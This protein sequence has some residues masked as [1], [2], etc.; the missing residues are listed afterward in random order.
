L[1][2]SDHHSERTGSSRIGVLG[3]LL[4]AL[5]LSLGAA[6]AANAQACS[7]Y[8]GLL[9]GFAGDIPPPQLQIDRNCTIRN[10]PASN[11]LSTN[12]SFF[13]QPGQND[14]RYLVVFDNVVHTGQMSCNSNDVQNHKIWFTNGSSTSI[15]DKCQELLIP[16]EK[17]D[18][19]NPAGQTTAAIGVPFTY[20]LTI[21][22]LFDP[23]T[24][25]VI[26]NAGS[27]N[28]LHSVIVT[29]DLNATN[30]DLSYVS[31]TA[32]WR[33]S[34]AAVPHA[35]SNVGG[36][37]TFDIGPI[38]PAGEQIDIAITVVLEDT[39]TNAPGTPF[40]NTAKWE[41]GR[42]I[43]GVFYEP[44]PGEWGISPPLT[45]AAPELVMTKTG[46]AT[47]GLTLNLGEWGQFGL[48]VE[49]TGLTDAWDITL[50]DQLP[51]PLD[52]GMCATTPEI[53]SAEIAESGGG[54]RT[55]VQGADY[56]FAYAGAPT[57]EFTLSLLSAAGPLAPGDH[58]V[59]GYR[60]RLDPDTQDGAMLTNVA[61]ATQWFNDQSGN[62]DR[63]TFPRSLTD[64]T[65]GDPDH[66]DAHT[67]TAAL[68]GYFFEKSVANLTTG[69]SPT[70]TATPG[71][72]LRYTLR[73]QATDVE[74]TD[75]TIRDDLGALNGA[76]VFVPGSLSLV[77]IPAGATDNSLPGGGTN[78]AGLLEIANLDVPAGGQVQI[79]FDIQ[80]DPSLTDG[81]LVLNQADL[82]SSGLD[83]ADSDDPNINGQADPSVPGDEDPTQVLVEA[84]P[85]EPLSKANTQATATIGET[86]S[87]LVTLPSIPHTA[88]LYDVRILDDLTLSA[89]DL[90][91]VSVSTSG[92]WTLVNT[93]S[94]T[95]LV[96]E[97]TGTGIDIP[98]GEQIEVEITVRL[99]D[100]GT[101]VAGLD[102][103]NTATFTYNLVNED[104]LS[105]RPGGPGTTGPMT[106][107]EPE[108]TLEKTGP[109]LMTPGTAGSF[110]L[111]VHNA[112]GSPAWAP[113]ITDAL[114]DGPTGGTCDAMPTNVA[115]QVFESDGSTPVSGVLAQGTDY[116]LS[117]SGTLGCL[118][119][120]GVLSDQ[121]TI[122][123]DQRL[124]ISYDALLDGDTQNGVALTNVAGAVEWFGLDDGAP[125]R[126]TYSEIVTD[127]TP[128]LLDHQDVHTVAVA[129]PGYRF[130]K[131]VTN[132]TTGANPA[133]TASPG[134][135]LLYRLELT[136]TS[137]EELDELAIVDELDALN[138]PAAFQ[139]DTLQLISTP[140]GAITG[141]TLPDGGSQGTG[142]LDVRGLTLPAMGSLSVEFQIQ[143]APV[144]ANG[145]TVAN[146]SQLLL[147]DALFALS[148]DPNVNGQADPFVPDDE[149]PTRLLIQSAP[150]FQVQKISDDLT[151][152][153]NVLLAGETLRYTIRVKN[154]G[155]DDASDAVLRDDVPVNTTYVPGSTTLNGAP[156][157]DG[158]GG[159]SP[160]AAG[161]PINAPED[162]TPGAMR[163]DASATPD[164]VATL[165]FD[166][167]V[168]TGVADGTLIA[169]QGFVSA[170]AGNVFDT[171]SDDPNTPV[172]NDPTRDVVGSVPLL[173][174]TKS[175]ELLIDNDP[176]G[177]VN[178]LDV[179]HY[180]IE[181]FNTG[182]VPATGV[183]VTDGV[184][185][186]TAYVANSTTLNTL[187][188]A[189]VGGPPLA[190]GLPISSSDLTPPLP[191]P[192]GGTISVGGSALIEFDLQ[193]D[194]DAQD[195]TVISNQ[196]LVTGD[197]TP[198]L[199]T[200]GDGDP[201][202]G[203]EPT[204]VVV[205]GGPQLAITKQVAVV[206]GGP[207][208][209]G[210]TVEY[211]VNVV[212]IGVVAASSVVI[213][214]DV[215]P[216][217]SYVDP[218]AT[219]NGSPAGVSFA[220]TT[221]TA[222]Y[223]ASYGDLPSGGSAQL[224]FRAVIDPNPIGT[225]VT[226]T[227][228]VTWNTTETEQASAS[229][230]VGG[231][232]G[233]GVLSGRLWHDVDF[234]DVY[235]SGDPVL[236]G[237]TVELL[238][239]G[240][241]L[242]STVS[243]ADGSYSITGVPPNDVSGDSLVL[244]FRAPDAGANSASLGMAASPFT[245]GPQE[246]S[247]I[248]V[249]GG[250]IVE[251]LNLPI[252]PNGVVY[253]ALQRTPVVGATLRMLEPGSLTELPSD[254]FEDPAQQGQVTRGDGFYKF[255]LNFGQSAC[256]SPGGSYLI[257]VTPPGA[258]FVAG[259]SQI[260]P[261]ISDDTT[262]PLDV[263]TCPG[264][265]ND[266]LGSPPGFCEA[267]TFARIPVG[268]E[269]TSY[270]VH[271]FLGD[272]NVPGTSQIF[273]N[274]IP[275]D[276]VLD[277]V[278]AI[279]K[280]TPLVNVSRGQLVPYEI[281]VR[282][283]FGADLDGV[284]IVDRFPPGFHYVEGSAQIDGVRVE[285][286][287][288][289]R[290]LV[291]SDLVLPAVSQRRL[292]LL[293][294]VG[295]G[296]SEG[297]FVNRAQ[298]IRNGA[299]L[300]GQA[301]ATVRVVPDPTFD[302]TDVL[303][304]VFDDLDRDGIQDRGERGL[305]GVRLATA[306]G[307]IATTD[308]HG[309]F[310]ITCAITPRD[311]RGS[312]FV[313]KLDD[314][315]LPSGYR[316]STRQV[317]VKRATAGK[318]LRFSYGASIHRVVG[319]DLADAVFEPGSA[320]MRPQWE[321]RLDLLLGELRKAPAILRLS[322]VADVESEDLVVRR[323]D[324]IK[325]RIA[326][327]WQDRDGYELT[328]ETEIFWRRGAPLD[329]PSLPA[330]DGEEP[331]LPPVS[332]GP[333]LPSVSAGPPPVEAGAGASAERQFP[334][335]QPFVQWVQDPELLAHDAS[336]RLEEREV[337]ADAV[338]TV[339]LK[340]VVP[341]VRFESGV[342]QISPS[343]IEELR[344]V[345]ESMRHLENVRL[346]L[347]GHA[348]D[349]PLSSALSNIYGD[350]AGLSR[351]RAGE[352]AEFIQMALG[353][354]P[355]AISF[356]WAGDSQPVAS[357]AT[358]EG[359]ALNRRVEVEVWYDEIGQQIAREEVVVPADIKRIKVC[360]METVCKL[361]Y[362]EGHARRSRI[363]NLIPPLR[364]D[365]DTVGVPADFI[366]QLERTLH[367][368]RDKQNV[369]V[370][371]IGFTDDV[372][373]AGRA[374][375][376]Y[377]T[378]LSLSKAR[379][380]R[381]A[382]AV[383]DALALPSAA[384]ASDGYGAS[385]PVASNA[386][387]QGRTLNRRVEVEFWYDDPLQELP[388][389]PQPCPDPA[390]AERVTRVYDPPWG[391][392]EPIPVD[393]GEFRVP[394]GYADDLRRAMADVAD[395][396]HVR[397]RFV[398][399]TRNQRL[400]RRTAAVYGD[401]IGLS[402]ARARR[403]MQALQA[404]L[405][406]S[407]DQ[408]EHE[409][410]GYV[411]SDDVVNGGFIQGD[412]SHVAAQVVYDELAVLD[413]YEG[414]D[415]TP[416]TRELR[417][418]DPLALNLMRITVDG[419][420]LDDPGRSSADIQRCTD[421]AL[422]RTDVSFRFDELESTP[423]LSVTARP[424]VPIGNAGAEGA[425]APVHFRAYTNYAHF[426]ERSEVR[427]FERGQ[428]TQAEPL[429]VVPVG[430]DGF[431]HWQTDLERISAPAKELAYVLR[432]YDDQGRFDETAP[433]SLWLV[434]GNAPA[435]DDSLLAGYGES[436]VAVRGISLGSA[437]AVEVHGHGIPSDHS[438]WFA[439]TPV[440][441]DEQG[442]FVAQAILPVG[443]HTVE[444]AVLDPEGN[445]EL[446]LRDLELERSD[447]FYVGIADLTFSLS[448][449]SGNI[450]DLQGDNAPYDHDS[451]ADG[452]LAF[453]LTGEFAED[454]KLTASADTREG[455]IEDLF[456]DFVDK[457]PEALFRRIDPDYHYPTFGD[458][459]SVEET[460][461]TSGKFYA[462]LSQHENHLLWGNFDVGYLDNELA[463]VDRGLYGANAHYQS[464]GTTRFGEQRLVLD[465]FAAEPG[466]L[467]S[468]EEFRGT[469]GS[470]Y[471]L[472]HQDLLIGSERVRIEVRDKDSGLVTSV[473][474]LRPELDYDVDY[475][476]GRVLLS[477]PIGSTVND[478]LLVRSQGLSGDEAWLVVQYEFTPGFVELD[479][480]ATGGQGE[481]WI[482][483]FLKLGVT[484]NRNEERNTDSSLY[485]GDLTARLSA[486]SWAKVQAGRSEGL[487]STS[488]F[489]SDGGFSFDDLS[490]P[491]A[492]PSNREADALRADLSLGIGDFLQG[493]RGRLHVYAQQ[494]E[495]G[496]SAPGMNA[497]T[498]TEYLGGSLE[499][500]V[501]QRVALNAKADHVDQDHGLQTRTAE[502][503]VEVHLTD[504]WSLAAGVRND[505]RDDDSLVVPLT[506]DQGERTDAV[507]QAEF[508]SNSSW[509][510]YVFGQATVAKSGGRD[511][512]D[513]V[514]VGGAYRA[515]ERLML[516]GEVSHGSHGPA[517]RLG[518]NYQQTEETNLYLNY[519]LENERAYDAL[520]AR[521][522]SNLI[523]G[524]RTR[525]SDS[526]SVYLENRL[527][528]TGSST[529][530]T[531]TMGVSLVPAER[532]SLGGNWESGTLIDRRT[533][534]ETDR[535]SGGVHVG[536]AFDDLQLSSGFEYRFD[537]TQAALN[538]TWS[539]R[540][541]WLLRNSFKYQ[542]TP[543][544][545]LLGK[546]NHSESESSLG[547][548]FDGGY[549]E[550][551]LGYAFRPV[552]HDRLDALAKYTYFYNVPTTNQVTGQG[553][554]AQFIQKSH[555]ASIDVTYDL[556]A[557]W[558]VG[559][560]YAYRLGQVSLDRVNP[561][562][563]DNNAHLY[564]LRNDYRFLKDWEGSLEGRM[565]HLPD[566]DE[567]RSGALVTLYRYF[568]DHFK[569][570]VGY[571]FTD[572]SDDLTD[573]DYDEHGV[574]LNL[575]G[576]L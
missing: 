227:G 532:W 142:L 284:E 30:V 322:Y 267:Q 250:E 426:I 72:T 429:A 398:G 296:V 477:Q 309:R 455:P 84:T 565:L 187:A 313:L 246:I 382:R 573:L 15:K 302:C 415:V 534:A 202:T 207:A 463:H 157:P 61:G 166:V 366:R 297:E 190:A 465:G 491:F 105:Q 63:V 233:V 557:N 435:P 161:I 407:D 81:T 332:A 156:I 206:G 442:N 348:D 197:D 23:G 170:P 214:D 519:A 66:E 356:E 344:G 47:L 236:V 513:R 251:D 492:Q 31:H 424:T 467:P 484:A 209:A 143:L 454:W 186:D 79:V 395:R 4:L 562:F 298:A 48:D 88:P 217:L 270:H 16:V 563:F 485:A 428:S 177:V 203:P 69:A 349:Q 282:N 561:R 239:N 141:G 252:D 242:L 11:P 205:G 113:T 310:H 548:F 268:P 355:E 326:Q 289:G 570:G 119:T 111:D 21:P 449:S 419:E 453:Y 311:G 208:L 576:T 264:S 445:G 529:G 564:I 263:P 103:A 319:L 9:D 274:H 312:N 98:A 75:L 444:V 106:I 372:P 20:T 430:R 392:I 41:F 475:L 466:T 307:L 524:A 51:D 153:P 104:D 494:L 506:Q 199:P 383:Q 482:N 39:I 286:T 346:H 253:G 160:L 418:K 173:F 40:I 389:D 248:L 437:G 438:V 70:A 412:T 530:L 374:E 7:D 493:A 191:G 464:Q 100:T 545:R 314:R 499:L 390:D 249:S 549:T 272:G 520:Y 375:R 230:D 362:R 114:P 305:P 503:D 136:N 181:V 522:G 495:A 526:S 126:R 291:W 25:T 101:N 127:G 542:M 172:P 358:P 229:F 527:Q 550:G 265:A 176:Q 523:T 163:A 504:Y 96:I 447:W 536:Y 327:A 112:G 91:L 480:L 337:L 330:A 280:T 133:T 457:T 224:R 456:D 124:I 368:L 416:I 423:R 44:L 531:R 479:A 17:I 116:S 539:D 333:P 367:N 399:Y 198:D 342:A 211:L 64:G 259:Y 221:L 24:G 86:F 567:R 261:P 384:V 461:P 201:A 238:R 52:G 434:G 292:L 110:R 288:L 555:V 511:G 528:Y 97:G 36:V 58:L 244:R 189:D 512:N 65:P 13:T 240:T 462:K 379:A 228:V 544:G 396:D 118:L 145:S 216:E 336:D 123:P 56:T 293:L 107:V 256:A 448:E 471:W 146:Q 414:V 369:T 35:F 300:S 472:S 354:P 150:V 14:D 260:I 559:G 204:L 321:P 387:E 182:A 175:V 152:D 76:P 378:H 271:L 377:G 502:V 508:D 219:L 318:A 165:T 460:A 357:N 306:R 210:A 350:N 498:D 537:E 446:F 78:S 154:V 266:A 459:S 130:E 237:W 139:A 80:L 82:F 19:Q 144:I 373:L 38:I 174:A 57:C 5:A 521:R 431:A 401:D 92:P 262:A 303:G 556:T 468:R 381:V 281:T 394:P 388:D 452:R 135:V 470:L 148:D 351:E 339:K 283:A 125:L 287:P 12:F 122:G 213:T 33:G 341:P 476:Q 129:L 159:T 436:E 10:Y 90:E 193:V 149:D 180:T 67:V 241:P 572:F 89:A 538:G 200:D 71:D 325:R 408:V 473:V 54:T 397:L 566:L 60:A 290:D 87:Y 3:L 301:F 451:F 243:A 552:E 489:S 223:S 222:N 185:A 541:T 279:T 275:L 168:D 391:R 410:R 278:V 533:N 132:V 458:D 121:G 328:I 324:A 571:N 540:R 517:A 169:N 500:P 425:A 258:S 334:G 257:A 402:A 338:E 183:V 147:R 158:A 138:L 167:V 427:I 247:G 365:E 514:G 73:V 276:P 273:N 420:P 128:G 352:V 254:C 331:A 353:L 134:D 294:A 432:A 184:P 535:I 2:R 1:I 505:K 403:I 304:K 569:V 34:G 380:Q 359:R 234:D 510:S 269:P 29:D 433:Q 171:P 516:D 422:E 277:G 68:F 385:R 232:P 386:T 478:A 406:L 518:T 137:D 42:L 441:V 501:T 411:H 497:L 320:D 553:T 496:Y 120:I 94:I 547:D 329:T 85:P 560:K 361:R 192:G 102:F 77:S 525:L 215:P 83:I 481:Y 558:S 27:V 308:E 53:L 32:T 195:G 62:P 360:R 568:G 18:K 117:W 95:D 220:G 371:L 364:Y 226:N 574:F 340:D 575:V 93:G 59:V 22:V 151:G 417:P 50:V 295:A 179:L 8:G 178:P 483:D 108:L 469:G 99:S 488:L 162:P 231:I 551:V 316:M 45:I 376:I 400:D 140:G 421:V 6:S 507:V 474:H 554:S 486:E 299:P 409:G 28:D 115:V 212:N 370:K 347:V 245:D 131:T 285:P 26:N 363:K 49:N 317:Q 43:D 546:F 155:S 194:A 164:N 443:V 543:S 188:V 74:L 315:T 225:A 37:L 196:A 515:S 345:L 413:D 335:D 46:P 439:G 323:L 255:D 109:A 450:D 404:E 440:P 235:V 509:R 405:G 343:Y 393:D 218:S 55:L 487:V 490:G